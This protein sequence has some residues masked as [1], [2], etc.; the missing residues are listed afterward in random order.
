MSEAPRSKSLDRL[1]MT[2]TVSV[3]LSGVA[4]LLLGV[5]ALADLVL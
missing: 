3:M 1:L 2:V 4:V 5:Y